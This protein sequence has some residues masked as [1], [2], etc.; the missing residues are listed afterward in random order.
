MPWSI[1]VTSAISTNPQVEALLDVAEALCAVRGPRHREQA[2]LRRAISTA[3]YALFHALC[4]ACADG[5]VGWSQTDL[6][7]HI[8]RILDHAPARR[9]LLSSDALA[10]SPD[11]RRIG[12]HFATLQDRRHL[13]DYAPPSKDALLKRP[14]VFVAIGEART[15]AA[16]LA[17]LDVRTLQKLAL[18]LV[19]VR[20]SP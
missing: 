11:I 9:K 12:E 6:V 5:L 17:G 19:V 15:A 10:I 14:D 13:A 18:L 8:Y 3:Y 4:T 20:R 1:A 7:A 2:A 16:L